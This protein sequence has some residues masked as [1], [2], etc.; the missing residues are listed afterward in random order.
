MRGRFVVGLAPLV[1]AGACIDASGFSGGGTVPASD[2]GAA[3]DGGPDAL[4]VEASVEAGAPLPP[5]QHLF[6]RSFGDADEQ[7]VTRASVDVVGNLLLAGT[8]ASTVDFGGGPLTSAGGN[9]MYFA[10]LDPKGGH[11]FSKGFGDADEQNGVN[12]VATGTGDVYATG[13]FKGAFPIGTGSVSNLDV[14]SDA[15][16]LRLRSDGSTAESAVIGGAGTQFVWGLAFDGARGVF[17][18]GFNTGTATYPESVASAGGN[19]VLTSHL[20]STQN[21]SRGYGD[22]SEQFGRGVAYDP[23]G[24]VVSVGYFGGTMTMGGAALTSL[25]GYDLFV[26]KQTVAGTVAWARAFGALND[27]SAECVAV[28]AGGNIFVAGTFAGTFAFDSATPLVSAGAADIFLAKLDPSGA[29]LWARRFGGAGAETVSGLALDANGNILMNGNTYGP[30]DFGGGVLAAA[31]IVKLSPDGKHLW[32]HRFG[33]SGFQAAQGIG[34]APN[35]EVWAAGY[36]TGTI[37]LGGGP[38]TAV[39]KHDVWIARFS[40]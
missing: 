2:G 36:F 26:L 24:S 16:V 38:M 3:E 29:P 13:I 8:F 27:Q 1:M 20:M 23:S 6:S 17:T 14:A 21:W 32:S 34:A 11:V 7:Y 5:G 40:P 18:S 12:I 4:P 10:K 37:D 25:G 9:D 31:Y 19:D 28:D 22:A 30:I 39:G 15:L 35:G 33:D